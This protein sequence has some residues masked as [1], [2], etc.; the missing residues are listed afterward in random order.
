MSTFSIALIADDMLHIPKYT[1]VWCN[2]K[3]ITQTHNFTEPLN[4]NP[5]LDVNPTSLTT[6]SFAQFMLLGRQG[7]TGW[8]SVTPTEFHRLIIRRTI[9][10]HSCNRLGMQI[11]SCQSRVVIFSFVGYGYDR[12]SVVH[13]LRILTDLRCNNKRVFGMRESDLI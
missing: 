9:N 6:L 12:E 13:V 2:Q 3:S 11:L 10:F 8:L 4:P 7:P 1:W 5:S